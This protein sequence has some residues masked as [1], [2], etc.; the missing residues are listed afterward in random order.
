MKCV[1]C[2]QAETASGRAT[3]TLER[4]GLTLVVKQVPARI[5]PNCGE[6]YIDEG[7]AERILNG[8]EGLARIGTQ[9]AR[10]RLKSVA[11]GLKPQGRPAPADVS[12]FRLDRL[13]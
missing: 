4:D 6:E 3:L 10:I 11:N 1:I 12:F 13:Q 7:V 9:V 2:K 5:C 8:A